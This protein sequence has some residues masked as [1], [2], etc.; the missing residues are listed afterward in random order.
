MILEV[1]EE[2]FAKRGFDD[3]NLDMVA[4]RL[5]LRRQAIYF[6]EHSPCFEVSDGVLDGGPH[7]AEAGVRSGSG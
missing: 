3:S 4:N 6:A 1:P 2:F 7:L 5:G